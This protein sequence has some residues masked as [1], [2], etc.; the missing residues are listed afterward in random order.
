MN[1]VSCWR[2]ASAVSDPMSVHNGVLVKCVAF[3]CLLVVMAVR[4]GRP[5]QRYVHTYICI[6]PCIVVRR[7]LEVA[8]NAESNTQFFHVLTAGD[9]LC[10]CWERPA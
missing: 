10:T 6:V 3:T 8:F 9:A 5:P 2:P 4:R 1:M 7:V